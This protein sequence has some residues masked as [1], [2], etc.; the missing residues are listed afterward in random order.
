MKAT[1]LWCLLGMAASAASAADLGP[2]WNLARNYA[3]V[4]RMGGTETVL[5]YL[6]GAG[7]AYIVANA[8]ARTKNQPQLYCQP[9]D[10][11]LN[12]LNYLD[13]FE[14]ELARDLPD[15]VR[16]YGDEGVLLFGLQRTFPCKP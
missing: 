10:L 11:T 4:K 16:N 1:M 6:M 14:K 8:S 13:I 12:A 15:A 2:D 7:N 5:M 3:S 9:S